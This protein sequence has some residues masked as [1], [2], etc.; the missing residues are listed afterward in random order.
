MAPV[1]SAAEPRG[2]DLRCPK[3][4]FGN[5]LADLALYLLKACQQSSVIGTLEQPF[6]S[7]MRRRPAW[8]ALEGDGG[9]ELVEAHSCAF[10]SPHKKA[11]AILGVHVGLAPP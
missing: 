7:K 1:R 9:M 8:R 3:T 4:W 5:R 10:G 2:F 6:S 11:F